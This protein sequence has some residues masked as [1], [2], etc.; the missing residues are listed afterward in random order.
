MLGFLIP[1]FYLQFKRK[2]RLHQIP[3]QLIEVLGM[4][5][6]SMR[7][8]FSFMQAI[9]L[10]SKEMPDPIGPEFEKLVREIGLGIPLR[11]QCKLS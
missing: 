2:R 9:Q 10:A 5:A 3:Y 11:M 7:A 6:N 1:K 8:G 4:I